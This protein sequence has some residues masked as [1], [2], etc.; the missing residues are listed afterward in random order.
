MWDLIDTQQ[1]DGSWTQAVIPHVFCREQG[2]KKIQEE[3][4]S[5]VDINVIATYLALYELEFYYFDKKSE[6]KLV[7]MKG[8]KY[9]KSKGIDFD[10]KKFECLA[11]YY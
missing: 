3:D 5:L 4:P 9:L 10:S 8:K 1:V 11:E 7:A 2:V 6:W